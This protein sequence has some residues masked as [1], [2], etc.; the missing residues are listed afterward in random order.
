APSSAPRSRTSGAA[1]PG[2]DAAGLE[3]GVTQAIEQ[4]LKGVDGFL[5]MSSSCRASGTASINVTFAAGTDIDDAQVEVQNRLRSVEPRLPEEVR[6]Q[7][8]Q[9]NE[10]S[11]GFLMI[12]ALTS[13][14]GTLSSLELGNFASS[15]VVDELRRVPGVGDVFSFASPYAMRIWLDPYR[16][17]AF[18]LSAAD[19]LAA[20]REQN[21]QTPGGQLGDVPLA[22]DAELNAAIVTQGRFS[23][24]E[25]FAAIILRANPDGSAVRLGD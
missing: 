3:G 11:E 14:S 2:P 12:I 17:T 16:L 21:S 1:S 15:R 4:G 13:R 7:G 23:T 19:A 9:V 5:Y 22:G 24:P 8:V 18:R 10:A 20:V 6:Q 25:E